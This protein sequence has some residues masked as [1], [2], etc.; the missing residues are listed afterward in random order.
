MP[1]PQ[2]VNGYCRHFAQE[3]KCSWAVKLATHL[4]L[5]QR[6]RMSRAMPPLCYLPAWHA[7]GLLTQSWIISSYCPTSQY[8]HTVTFQKW[9]CFHFSVSQDVTEHNF[10]D[11]YQCTGEIR[12]NHYHHRHMNSSI[13]KREAAHFS[14]TMVSMYYIERCHRRNNKNDSQVCEV[15][16]VYTVLSDSSWEG[17]EFYTGRS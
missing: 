11:R 4:Y 1:R 8:V 2:C 3:V 5:L 17:T 10:V 14:K 7:Q 9:F 12:C 6:L 15:L 16:K 13:L